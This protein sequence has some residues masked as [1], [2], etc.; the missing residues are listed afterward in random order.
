MCLCTHPVVTEWVEDRVTQRAIGH[1]ACNFGF[2]TAA[3]CFRKRRAFAWLPHLPC[4]VGL[5]VNRA[6]TRLA[7]GLEGLLATA[8]V[9]TAG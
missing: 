5:L 8:G 6:T 4:Y 1:R 7:Q 3:L 9:H 2:L